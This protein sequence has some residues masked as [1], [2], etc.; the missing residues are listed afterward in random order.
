MKTEWIISWVLQIVVALILGQT[1]FF[2]FTAAPESVQLFTELGMEPH[3]RILIGVLELIAVL[4][5]LF[6][7]TVVF[8]A[9]LSWGVMS[10][11]IIGHLTEL[12]FAGD[13]LSLSLLAIAAWVASTVIL[14]LRRRSLPLVRCMFDRAQTTG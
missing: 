14:Y 6:P 13:R 9:L 11:A 10:G 7:N 3:G 2:K 12:G 5:L 8:G 4:L 1:L